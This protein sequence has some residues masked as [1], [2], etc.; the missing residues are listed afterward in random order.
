MRGES[1]IGV[2]GFV[3]ATLLVLAALLVLARYPAI[4][5]TGREYRAAFV[6]AAGLNRGSAV[7]FGGVAVG[8]VTGID[9]DAANPTRVLVRFRV[10]RSAPIRVD[11]HAAVG[12]VGLLGE[13]YLDLRAGRADAP[14]LPPGGTLASVE[15]PTLQETIARVGAFLDRAAGVF[16]SVERLARSAP[17][18]HVDSTLTRLDRL[19]A[20]ATRGSAG[21]FAQVRRT[22]TQLETLAEKATSLVA[23]LDSIVAASGPGLTATQREALAAVRDLE[24]LIADLRFALAQGEGVGEIVQNMTVASDNL[25]RLTTRI[26]RDPSSLLKKVSSP[27]K[28]VGPSPR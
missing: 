2:L 16:A 8:M 7:R 21:A 11:T 15:T 20:T 24:S 10:K 23:S 26:E 17:L 6:D 4:F 18:E 28:S 14:P 13:P 22:G 12:Q 1:R 27:P 5:R 19:V 3:G 9:I 25:A